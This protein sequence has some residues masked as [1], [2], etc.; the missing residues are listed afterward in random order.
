MCRLA[1][2]HAAGATPLQ[3]IRILNMNVFIRSCYL[4][5]LAPDIVISYCLGFTLVS[6][7]KTIQSSLERYYNI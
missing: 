3:T 4:G 5:I 7:G 6:L 1:T 2:P